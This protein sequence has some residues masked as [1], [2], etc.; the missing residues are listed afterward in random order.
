MRS[1]YKLFTKIFKFRN[2][3]FAKIKNFKDQP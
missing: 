3:G 1:L 2:I